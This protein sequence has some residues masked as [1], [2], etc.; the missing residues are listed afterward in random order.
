ME[1]KGYSRKEINNPQAMCDILTKV[2]KS[3]SEIDQDKEH[4]WVIGLTTKNTVKYLELVSLGILDASLVHPRE[5][6]RHAICSGV[7]SIVVA[8][9]HPSGNLEA[10]DNDL[11]VTRRLMEAG[12]VI[13]IELLD[14]IIIDGQGNYNSLKQKGII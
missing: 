12:K 4:F 6:Y 14:H 11:R 7:C 13:G 5:V 3:E 1:V 10:S 8:H 2:I 9:N